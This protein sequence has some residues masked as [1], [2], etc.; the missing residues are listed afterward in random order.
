M[1]FWKIN[2]LILTILTVI[3]CTLPTFLQIFQ[4]PSFVSGAE[5]L[6]HTEERN[7]CLQTRKENK[8]N[9]LQ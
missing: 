4:N 5:T 6:L 9:R 7:V 2:T 8:Q 3:T 1:D